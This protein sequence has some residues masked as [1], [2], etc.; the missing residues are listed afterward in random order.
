M[1]TLHVVP[2]THW[3]REWYFPFQTFRFRLVR[4]A[5]T[6][7]EILEAQPD[8]RA[9]TLDGQAVILEDVADVRPDLAERLR[10][11][12]REG[13]ILVG[14]WFILPDEFLVSPE[15]L[16]R[17]LLLGD[18]IC[19]AWGGKM[20]L[21]YLPDTFGHIAQLPQLLRGFGIETVMFA[22]GGGDAPTEFRWAA[23]DGSEVLA[24]HLRD[25]Y[26]VSYTHLTLPTK[27]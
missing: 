13:R 14:P 18:C 1:Y 11:H 26:A 12:I 6:L 3:D 17:N 10:R 16:V 22:R 9:F 25:H 4:L 5:E 24:C 8:Y 23:P 19:R 20:D 21:G 15:A 27:A 2:H 7:L